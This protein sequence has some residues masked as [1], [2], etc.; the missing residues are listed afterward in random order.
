[1]SQ[2][3]LDLGRSIQIVRRHRVFV[4]VVVTLA[5][6]GGAAYA[7]LKLPMVTSTALIAL[8]TS[9]NAQSAAA[10]TTGGTD[11]F[12]ATQEVVAGS[13]QVLAGALPNVRPAM[14]VTQLHHNIQVGSPSP[15]IIS[16]TAQGKNAADA[17]ANANA[18]AN[19]YVSYVNSPHSAVGHITAHLLES[20]ST[21]SGPAKTSRVVIY[22]L[23]GGLIGMLIGIIVVLAIGRSDRRLRAR[24]EIAN[25][26]GIP[27]LASV[28]VAHP[29]SAA[30]WT[31][32]F[33]SY[34]PAAVHA[35]QLHTALRQAGMTRR[36]RHAYNSNGNGS[37]LHHG[38]P[39]SMYD[40]DGGPF[41]LGVLSLS[42]D[43]RAL[44]LG[45]QLAAFAA[46]QEI[47][48][49]LVIGPQQDA[50]ATAT[51]RTACAAPPS[52]ASTRHGLLQVTAYDEGAVNLKP[53]TSLVVVVAVV[54]SRAPKMPD[55]IRTNA[56][57]LGVSAGATTAEQLARAAVAAA[58]D[59]REIT[60]ILV[61]D[62]DPADQT[63]GRVPYLARPARR[64]LPNRLRGI[65][66]EIRR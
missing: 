4:V 51:L 24:D 2:Q 11:P 3:A 16:I 55:T 14:S 52:E 18:V 12:T 61:A 29:S 7:V 49:A 54:D 64:G 39:A 63:T 37:S 23:V 8:P 6:L 5:V 20:A 65:A 15:D 36:G 33:E 66:T 19:S 40:G 9:T 44:A 53:D 27:V 41:T 32:L 57:V 17:E 10:T 60:G 47:P 31:K 59:G 50:A 34:K 21:A 1:M 58:A 45:P 30:G 13:S 22:A 48:T 46:S 35:W 38:D 42:S 25:S 56:T 62:P 26:I 43:S 28:P